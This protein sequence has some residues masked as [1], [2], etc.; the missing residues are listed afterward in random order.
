MAM[1]AEQLQ[2]R[3]SKKEKDIEKIQKRI[4]KWSKGLRQED[5]DACSD[6]QNCVYGP[7]REATPEYKA[8]SKKYHDYVKSHNDIPQNEDD[9]N[10][11]PNIQE[12]FRAFID[13]GEANNT[14]QKYQTQLANIQAFDNQEKIG[15]L[16]EFLTEWEN[17]C[18]EWYHRNSER[19]AELAIGYKK[20][21]K[22]FH[23]KFLADNPKPTDNSE[24]RDWLY[25]ERK[26]RQEFNERYYTGINNFTIDI[27]KL[28]SD[29]IGPERNEDGSRNWN[30]E[31]GPVAYIGV[32][33]QKLSKALSD[34]KKRKY[35]DLCR[36]IEDVV[37]E[38]TNA[39]NLSIGHQNGEING[40]VE[41][42]K[43]KASVETIGA[44]GYNQDIIVNSK[45]GQVFHFRVLVKK[46]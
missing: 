34:E 22:E 27:T 13:L 38:I 35:E 37:G 18:N 29:Y 9:W 31:Y 44:G 40:Y 6:M 46:L 20:A 14:L 24:Y 21:Y 42:T 26:A 8:A 39:S 10:K 23:D 43:G 15:P 7:G 12:T 17:K 19:Y 28:R 36:R 25:R 32:D 2:E 11:G 4:A 1:T 45:H 16:W 3:I 5:I 30:R 33:E 41:G